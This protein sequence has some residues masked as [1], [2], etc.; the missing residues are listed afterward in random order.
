MAE[1][2]CVTGKMASGKNYISKKMESEGY[3]SIDADILV[4]E[5]IN[6]CADRIFIEFEDAAKA[7]G[8]KIKNDDGSVNR[9]NL[10]V[11]LF[12]DET[13][14]AKQESIVYPEITKMVKAFIAKNS[15]SKIILNATVAYKTPELLGMCSKIIFVTASFLKR[16][17]RARK[18]DSLPYRQII[19][20]FNSQKE[21]LKDYKRFAREHNIPLEVLHN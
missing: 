2:I 6:L 7:K 8:L 5:A 18:R 4:H 12:S 1:L 11:L 19:S 3:L 13:L 20:R 21:L 9:R 16:L 14:L 10:G 17:I 15:S